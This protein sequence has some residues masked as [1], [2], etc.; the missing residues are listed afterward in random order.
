M[1]S[2]IDKIEVG[3]GRTPKPGFYTCDIRPLPNID[4][5]CSADALPF[6]NNSIKQLYSRHLIEHFTL[7]EFLKVLGEWNRVLK[8]GG[9]LYIV[10][11]N[12]LWHLQQILTGEHNS[13]YA[14]E[15]GINQR[16]WGFGSLFGWNQDVYDCHKFGYYFDL[17]K[18][19]LS[20][21][22]FGEITDLTNTEKSQENS[23]W[24]LEVMAI[25]KGQAMEYTRSR[26]YNHF[27]VLH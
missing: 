23:P 25:K 15:S 14:K 13:F 11:P 16:F 24:H 6:A 27:N 10:C 1:I 9:E 21:F 5:V 3:S 17:L 20:D 18:D 7:K 22:G 4:F 26:F 8:V 19:I 12:I 2:N